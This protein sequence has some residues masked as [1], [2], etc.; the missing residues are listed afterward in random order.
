MSD[1]FNPEA[2][3]DAYFS[4]NLD[5]VDA[6]QLRVW[7][8]EDPARVAEI[9][10]QAFVHGRLSLMA[11]RK[12]AADLELVE[13]TKNRIISFPKYII[14]IAAVAAACV[15]ALVIYSNSGGALGE[16]KNAEGVA[17]VSPPLSTG[18]KIVSGKIEIGSGQLELQM[19]SGATVELRDASAMELVDTKRVSISKGKSVYF[20]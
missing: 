18:E 1:S 3:L 2:A 12:P 13:T 4:G 8:D 5:E 15:T 7:I 6:T 16:I 14:S 10:D 19:E 17:W 11:A 20:A 9:A